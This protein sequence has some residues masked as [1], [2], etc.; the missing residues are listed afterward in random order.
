MAHHPTL[1]LD[2]VAAYKWY[3][4]AGQVRLESAPRY[5]A[6]LLGELSYRRPTRGGAMSARVDREKWDQRLRAIGMKG[7]LPAVL[8]EKVIEAACAVPSARATCSLMA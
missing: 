6:H 8:T 4:L 5:A 2:G 1:T 7:K 3:G